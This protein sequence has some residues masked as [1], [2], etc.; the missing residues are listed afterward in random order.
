MRDG[1]GGRGG[2]GRRPASR[3]SVTAEEDCVW[4][5]IRFDGKKGREMVIIPRRLR[6][7]TTDMAKC[8]FGL[9]GTKGG[10]GLNVCPSE[11][12]NMSNQI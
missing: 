5:K 8:I 4:E 10:H 3:G 11:I 1:R 2:D 9:C 6:V 7:D 12:R